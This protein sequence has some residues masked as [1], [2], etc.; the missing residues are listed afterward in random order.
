MK[1]RILPYSPKVRQLARLLR[2]QST[3]AEILLRK[4]LRGKQMLGYDFHRQKPIDEYV[5]DFYCPRLGLVVEIDGVTHE[6]KEEADE[7]R[8][9]K[10]ESFGLTVLR[11]RDE[12]VKWDLDGVLSSL[13][14][15]I[16]NKTGRSKSTHP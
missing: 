1:K 3:V 16:Q 11:F 5:V 7:V 4:A 6:G 14:A 2:K 13:Q 10:L 8:Q 9:E 12:E 15:R